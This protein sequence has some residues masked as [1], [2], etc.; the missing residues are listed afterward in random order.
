MVGITSAGL[1]A[2]AAAASASVI[3]LPIRLQNTYASV[4]FQAGTPAKPYRLLF[5][6]G[7]SS[8]WFV[9]SDCTDA[10]CPN[11]SGYARVGYNAS[12]SS[13]SVDLDSYTLIP[14]IDGDGVGGFATQDVFSTPE[15]VTPALEW[16]QTFLAANESSWRFITADGFLGLGFS[17][18]AENATSTLVETLLWDG[19]LDA[20]RFAV[21]Y[22]TNLADN[23]TQNGLLTIGGSHEDTYVDGTVAYVPLRKE[24]P[25]QLWRAA[26][27]SVNVLAARTPNATVTVRN[28]Q[29]PLTTD[30]EGTWP[31][32]NTTWPFYGSGAAVFDT[33]AGRISVPDEIIDAVY[34][35]LG[36]NV[37]KLMN[38]EERMECR[39]LNASW[40]LSF[41]LGEGAVEDDVTFTIRGDEFTEPGAQCMPP[42][43]NS[44][45][46]G[47]ALIGSAFL[48]RHYSV[49]DFGASS[50]DEYQPK[51][52]FGRLKKEY[53][54]LYQ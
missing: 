37:T 7:S 23:G 25:Y 36:W 50:V 42:V 12:A 53:D 24:S 29:P 26:L 39:H 51:L 19:K 21:Y 52:G 6:T 35:N 48:Q 18:I 14:Y 43:D 41:T 2:A 30:P 31:T 45:G 27:R 33:G 4:E 44:G 15:G 20:P 54:Y 38:G 28:G 16:N 17:S 47:F 8:A 22:G 11:L 46:N 13:T 40:A 1:L 3:D 5:D 34:F 10:S 32:S 9:S 49:F